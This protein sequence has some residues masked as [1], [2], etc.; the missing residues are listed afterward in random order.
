MRFMFA[1]LL[2]GGSVLEL[3]A[4]DLSLAVS[5]RLFT[6]KPVAIQAIRCVSDPSD[7]FVCSKD[8]RS[9]WIVVRAIYLGRASTEIESHI[10][11]NCTGTANLDQREC[12]FDISFTPINDGRVEPVNV[13]SGSIMRTTLQTNGLNIARRR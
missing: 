13:G 12:E 6:G 7:G 11:R 5:P 3:R 10:I 2:F 4:D 9:R 8:L 1:I